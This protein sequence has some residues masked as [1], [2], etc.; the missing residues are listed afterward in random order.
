MPV[1]IK[2]KLIHMYLKLERWK[3]TH[4]SEDVTKTILLYRV[5]LSIYLW[6]CGIITDPLN[7]PSWHM[8]STSGKQ[9]SIHQPAMYVRHMSVDLPKHFT[10]VDINVLF[11]LN[12]LFSILFYKQSQISKLI[13]IYICHMNKCLDFKM[14]VNRKKKITFYR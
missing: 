12:F 10:K 8:S 11:S 3:I 2:K 5:E 13:R 7:N 9:K 1:N 6:V 4:T 14:F